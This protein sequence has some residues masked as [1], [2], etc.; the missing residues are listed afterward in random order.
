MPNEPA[1]TG[2]LALLVGTKILLAIVVGKSRGF[3]K[4]KAYI[5]TIR[6]LGVALCVFALMLFRDGLKLLGVW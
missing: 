5:Y 1:R 3:L 4:G 2:R 6:G